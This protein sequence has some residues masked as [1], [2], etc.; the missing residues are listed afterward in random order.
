MLDRSRP[1]HRGP[2][3]SYVTAWEAA[4]LVLVVALLLLIWWVG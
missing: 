4:A 2:G 3:D 1:H